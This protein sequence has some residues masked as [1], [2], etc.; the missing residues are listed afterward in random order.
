MTEEQRAFL[1]RVQADVLAQ[2]A[3]L[4]ARIPD[5]IAELQAAFGA[6]GVPAERWQ[7][8]CDDPDA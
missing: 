5:P 6:L 8:L 2:S 4:R 3:E 7:E 1:R